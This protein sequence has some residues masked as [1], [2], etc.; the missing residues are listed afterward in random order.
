MKNFVTHKYRHIS[1]KT[2]MG[3]SHFTVSEST[4]SEETV[5]HYGKRV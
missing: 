3:S 4:F 2:G 5:E 1:R